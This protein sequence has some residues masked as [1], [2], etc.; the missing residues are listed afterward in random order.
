MEALIVGLTNYG[1]S[2]RI[3]RLIAADRGRVDA[4]AR[5]A[6]RSKKRFAGVLEPGTR[7]RA[8]L[9]V[10]RGEL[11]TLEAADR[12][13][14]PRRARDDYDRLVLLSYGCEVVAR[15]CQPEAPPGRLFGLLEAWLALLEGDEDPTAASRVSLELKALTFAGLTPALVS[16]PVCGKALDA[17][18]AWSPEQG[19]GVHTWCG[20]GDSVLAAALSELELLRRTP[21]TDTTGLAEKPSELW[22]ITGF[23]EYWTRAGLKSRQVLPP[24]L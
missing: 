9:R 23:I 24:G 20:S 16:C 6:R 8:T 1:D 2:D 7:I 13:A 4:I 10:G 11:P 18:V 15:L 17:Q 21:M 14:G 12:L 5:G 3:V 22:L 19:G